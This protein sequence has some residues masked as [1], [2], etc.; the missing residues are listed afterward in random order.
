[1]KN[2]ARILGIVLALGTSGCA[3]FGLQQGSGLGA[4]LQQEQ[5]LD[6][7]WSSHNTAPA[8]GVETP[9]YADQ[10]LGALWNPSAEEPTAPSGARFVQNRALGSLWLSA[11][12][13]S[14][15]LAQ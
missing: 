12:V 1:M 13:P 7:L 14:K 8:Q 10:D 2:Q 11:S 3:G 6:Q 15:I 4:R 5:G 9:L